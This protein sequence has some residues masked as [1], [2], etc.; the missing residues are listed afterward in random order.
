MEYRISL[1]FLATIWHILLLILALTLRNNHRYYSALIPV[2]LFSAFFTAAWGFGILFESELAMRLTWI[3][4]F[5]PAALTLFIREMFGLQSSKRFKIFIWSL[6]VVV[7]FGGLTRWC[8]VRIESYS[9]VV[10][11]VYGPLEPYLRVAAI[12]QISVVLWAAVGELFSVRQRKGW[13]RKIALIGFSAYG[14]GGLLTAALLPLFGEYRF[15]ESASYGS[16]IWTT[17]AVWYVF[18]ELQ[19]R[20][21]SLVELDTFK[22]DFIN[23]VTHEF[24]TPLGAISSAVEIIG[25]TKTDERKKVQEY[26]AMID[27]NST[28]LLGFVNKLLDLA[29][30]QQAKV[31]LN[32]SEADLLIVVKRV[33]QQL[34]ALAEKD[35]TGIAVNG[36]SLVC[37]C[38]EEKIEQVITNLISNAIKAA[39]GGVVNINLSRNAAQIQIE[40]TDNGVGIDQQH[41][42]HIFSSFYQVAFKQSPHKGAGLGL[43]IAKGWIEAHGGKI[44]AE[45]EGAGKGTRVTFTVKG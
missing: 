5:W 33:I 19:E 6:A 31:Q 8:L 11:A 28:R 34:K 21:A 40:V 36:D 18:K 20:N 44:W 37:F 39:P 43:T 15:L 22:R 12:I 32:R 1:H 35:G 2:C 9:P 3:G 38:D 4:S 17:F 7:F 29:A 41:L 14:I 27:S 24:K 10:T 13:S 26:L 45:S 42:Q 30:I 16:V 23:H 25:Q